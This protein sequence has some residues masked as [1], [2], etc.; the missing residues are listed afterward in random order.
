MTG[1][2]LQERLDGAIRGALDRVHDRIDLRAGEIVEETLDAFNDL[3]RRL[4]LPQL[5]FLHGSRVITAPASLVCPE[6]GGRIV[7]EI[8]GHETVSRRPVPEC[9]LVSCE[10]EDCDDGI[11]AHR[12]YFSDWHHIFVRAERWAYRYV[13]V[14][15]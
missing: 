5:L 12:F 10:T 13:R 15:S 8:T 1:G 11:D 4:L 6:C 9:V 14:M 7:I 2:T 3:R